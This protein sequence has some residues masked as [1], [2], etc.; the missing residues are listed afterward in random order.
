MIQPQ[1]WVSIIFCLLCLLS[2]IWLFAQGY[3]NLKSGKITKFGLDAFWYFIDTQV[4]RFVEL[5]FPSKRN[6][7][8]LYRKTGMI[9]I[10]IAF[11]LARTAIRI[12]LNNILL[13]IK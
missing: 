9:A 13:Y 7:S 6:D 2:S 11:V 10:F 4:R 1:G 8:V 3:V 12:Y 5:K